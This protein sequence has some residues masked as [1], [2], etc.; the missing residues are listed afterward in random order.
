[1]FETAIDVLNQHAK[2]LEMDAAI[3]QDEDE[4]RELLQAAGECKKA[5]DHLSKPKIVCSVI[6]V[7][8]DFARFET[9]I[10]TFE[11]VEQAKAYIESE[12]PHR[13]VHIGA[14]LEADL[15]KSDAEL[16]HV[17]IFPKQL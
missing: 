5:A 12:Y 15:S 11:T 2:E 1:M 7:F 4:C 14:R 6:D 13:K 10:D 8:Y 16:N 9:F 3:L 17:W